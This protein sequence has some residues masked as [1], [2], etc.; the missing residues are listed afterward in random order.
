MLTP[1]LGVAVCSA[2]FKIHD[3]HAGK[4]LTIVWLWV[5]RGVPKKETCYFCDSSR[6]ISLQG[7]FHI[8]TREARVLLIQTRI[9]ILLG[10]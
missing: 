5:K 10:Q 3:A 6:G 8:A 4:D 1:H 7:I 2:A 9:G